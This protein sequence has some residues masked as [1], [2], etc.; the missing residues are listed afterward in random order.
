MFKRI[1]SDWSSEIRDA[2]DP[3]LA[4]GIEVL[5]NN[6]H[7]SERPLATLDFDNTCIY[8]DIT[9]AAFYHLIRGRGF[10]FT[11][12][13]W[14]GIPEEYGRNLIRESYEAS[15]HIPLPEALENISYKRYRYHFHAIYFKTY[16]RE[17][18]D[19]AFRF[20]ARVFA[21]MTPGDVVD[22]GRRVIAAEEARPYGQTEIHDPDGELPPLTAHRGLRINAL[23]RDMILS[24]HLSGV[25]TVLVTGSPRYLA[26][27]YAQRIGLPI[28]DIIGTGLHVRPDGTFSNQ[29]V[30]PSPVAG[31]KIDAIRARFQRPPDIAIGDSQWDIPM[32][33]ICTGVTIFVL[34]ADKSLPPGA[35]SVHPLVQRLPPFPDERIP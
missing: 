30:E 33:S 21:G 11:E 10:A 31:T 25:E 9:E 14:E 1:L 15:R 22:A 3:I 5:R 19:V 27:P 4:R 12:D 8:N 6:G 23:M 16:E 28:E 20:A 17:G 18:A 32:M 2:L 34:Q 7:A 13:F 24:L 35:D 26:A 29:V